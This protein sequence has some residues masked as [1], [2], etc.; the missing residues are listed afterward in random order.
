MVIRHCDS[1]WT[2]G[3]VPHPHHGPRRERG[4]VLSG[5]GGDR[6]VISNL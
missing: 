6:E 1:G 2:H 4:A 5:R 3:V